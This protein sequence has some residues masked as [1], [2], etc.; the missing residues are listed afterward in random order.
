MHSTE[1][2]EAIHEVIYHDRFEFDGN[3][4]NTDGSEDDSAGLTAADGLALIEKTLARFVWTNEASWRGRVRKERTEVE[5]EAVMDARQRLWEEFR[6]LLQQAEAV[7]R[8]A[9]NGPRSRATLLKKEGTSAIFSVVLD[10]NNNALWLK[11]PQGSGERFCLFQPRCHLD[12]V[13]LLG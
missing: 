4:S 6:G 11:V 2:R 10:V 5:H 3:N 1:A 9:G 13:K 7:T 8:A 12:G